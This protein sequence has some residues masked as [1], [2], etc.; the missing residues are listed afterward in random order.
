MKSGEEES[1][2]LGSPFSGVGVG[3]GDADVEGGLEEGRDGKPGS[4][5]GAH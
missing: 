4:R 3:E 1:L 2:I 5:L